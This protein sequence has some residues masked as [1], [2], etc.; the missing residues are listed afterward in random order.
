MADAV[1]M[2]MVIP[3]QVEEQR[4]P[5]REIW[6][7]SDSPVAI[8]WN[9]CGCN[10]RAQAVAAE[11]RPRCAPHPTALVEIILE[12]FQ[13]SKIPIYAVWPPA[14]ISSAGLRRYAAQRHH[15]A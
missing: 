11:G 3:F 14:K 4:V 15:A 7:A 6:L 12:R 10:A 13:A 1:T 9:Q 5:T 2:R 8:Q